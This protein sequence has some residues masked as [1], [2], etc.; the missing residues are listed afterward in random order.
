MAT[1]I[2]RPE[3]K[4]ARSDATITMRLPA[5][6]RDLIDTAAAAQGKSR[7]EFMVES[8]RL[9]AVDV[10]LDQRVFTLDSEQ[11]LALAEVLM[12]PPKPNGALRELMRSKA[13]WE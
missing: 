5:R 3:E 9:H 8:A 13:P 10:L 1:V 2:E 11:S 6:T 12:N 7:T 4:R